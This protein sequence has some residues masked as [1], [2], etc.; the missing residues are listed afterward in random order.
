MFYHNEGQILRQFSYFP[1]Q[2]LDR[3]RI[4]IYTNLKP[5]KRKLPENKR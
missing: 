4:I 5:F 3:S 1:L 2:K